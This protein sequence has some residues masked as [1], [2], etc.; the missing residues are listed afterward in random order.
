MGASWAKKRATILTTWE[1]RKVEGSKDVA[2]M[3]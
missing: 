2:E 1:G 3:N